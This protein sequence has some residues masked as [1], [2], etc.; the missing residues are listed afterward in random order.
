[1]LLQEAL[2]DTENGIYDADGSAKLAIQKP[3]DYDII[4][5]LGEQFGFDN[6]TI[7]STFGSFPHNHVAAS[8][9]VLQHY[10]AKIA[11]RGGGSGDKSLR[12]E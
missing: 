3:Y 2:E 6:G 8:Y 10:L 7:I 9:S 4:E 5:T 1:M 12:V 11:A